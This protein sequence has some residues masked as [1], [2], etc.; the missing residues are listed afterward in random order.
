MGLTNFRNNNFLFGIK[1]EDRLRHVYAIGKTGTGKSTLLLNMAIADI[2]KGH[3]VCLIDPHG[4]IAEQVLEYIPEQ[5]IND[6]IYFDPAD[7]YYVIAF[8]PLD[9]IKPSQAHLVVSGLIATFKNIWSDSWGP[10]LE[11]ILRNS[12]LTLLSY[13]HR[14]LLDIQPLLTNY[15]F[16]KEVLRYCTDQYLRAFWYN[17]FDKYSAP[18][19][20]EMISP[21]LNKAGLFNTITQLRNIVGPK[22]SAL[23][24]ANIMN[25]GKVLIC[26]LSK[27]KLGEDASSLLGSMIV[28]AIQ[29]AAL[30]RAA[31]PEQE[32]LP[33]YVYVDEMHSFVSLAFANILS[34]A[35][36]YKLSLFLTHQYL[37][38]LSEEIR[39]A[40]FGNVG[41]M[42]TFQV[43]A[44]D[45]RY[46]AK[47][48]YPPFDESDLLSL[49]QYSMY[50]KMMINGTTSKPFS[51]TT[52]PL[53]D[54]KCNCKEAVLDSSTIN[55]GRLK[56]DVEKEIQNKGDSLLK[57][58]IKYSLFD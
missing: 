33:F 17:E 30:N 36:K 7:E 6:V 12:L 55:Y 23:D 49:P 53:S 47:E 44:A 54:M 45:A 48:F 46:L 10:R 13:P 15:E 20:A 42:I 5:R 2:Q 58:Q 32:R 18:M 14:S 56:E 35:R 26:N 34:E 11:Y 9:N 8:N 24:I 1:D 22:E 25:T 51:A 39:S 52:L 21:I 28:N 3:G 4:D 40:I 38:Q 19:K 50:I 16:R 31:I 43:G 27:G 57:V 41:T 29:L 37:E